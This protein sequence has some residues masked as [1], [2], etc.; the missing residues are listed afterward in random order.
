MSIFTRFKAVFE[1]RA[2]QVADSFE[3]PKASLDYS[4]TKLE[5]SRVQIGRSLIDV[6]AAKNRLESQRAQ[7]AAALEKYQEQAG[8]AVK[9]NRDDLARTALERKQ[10]AQAR[11]DELDKNIANLNT[12]TEALKQS[13]VNLDHKIALFRAKKEE[14]KA[15]YDSSRAQLQMREALSGISVDLADVGNTIQRAEA[16]IRE[17]QSRSDAIEKLISEGI[18]TDV[19][20]PETD[21]VD[22]ELSRIGRNQA[23]E[24]EL[25]RLKAGSGA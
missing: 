5:E 3:D 22:R 1:S 18:F 14:L 23:V 10:D 7:L 16:R 11:Q 24:D 13:E 9:A 25:N 17:M 8:S 15:I 6:S 21:D 12:Q 20:E 2:N 4:L 19:L